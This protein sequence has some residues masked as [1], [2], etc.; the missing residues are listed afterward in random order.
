MIHFSR[1]LESD[2]GDRR[3][4]DFFSQAVCKDGCSRSSS[5]S[6]RFY[7]HVSLSV[8][9]ADDGPRV[10]HC[11][12]QKLAIRTGNQHCNEAARFWARIFG[13]KCN[14]Y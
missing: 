6:I 5:D 9:A 3:R 7:A 2:F 12:T 13:I 8:S 14:A 11:H 4:V 1:N 10:A